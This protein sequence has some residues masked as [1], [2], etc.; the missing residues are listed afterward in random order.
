MGTHG[1]T[2]VS[3]AILGSVAET[4]VRAAPCLV[5]TVPP[6]ML[7]NRAAVP[8]VEVADA[9]SERPGRRGSPV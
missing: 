1:R 9:L 7:E 6:A 3:H 2:G 8:P 4:V 5:L